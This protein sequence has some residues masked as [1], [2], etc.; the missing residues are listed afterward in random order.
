MKIFCKT[1]NS[2]KIK[3]SLEGQAKL[4]YI[5]EKLKN[6]IKFTKTEICSTQGGLCPFATLRLAHYVSLGDF[7]YLKNPTPP[8]LVEILCPPA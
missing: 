1:S 2:W 5:V 8:P 7:L 6:N 3:F 4:T